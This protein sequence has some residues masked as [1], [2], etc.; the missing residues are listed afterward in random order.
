MNTIAII[1]SS[2]FFGKSLINHYQKTAKVKTK[3]YCISR[4]NFRIDKKNKNVLI[5]KKK[6][7]LEKVERLPKSDF[8]FYFIKHENTK[9]TK[10]YFNHFLNLLSKNNKNSKILFSSSGSVY[11]PVSKKKKF[12]ENVK[13]NQNNLRKYKNYKKKY[14]REKYYLEKKF[15]YLAKKGFKVSI[16]RC[17]SFYGENILR[18]N[19]V[20]SNILN[21]VRKKQNIVLNNKSN[22]LR[23]YMHEKDLARWLIKIC[24]NSNNKCPI[25]NVGSNQEVD[26]IKLSNKI[27]KK[28]NLR[29]IFKNKNYVSSDY[30]VPNTNKAKKVLN[31]SNRI[32]FNVNID[33]LIKKKSKF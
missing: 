30:Y 17:F 7:S 21:A 11:G 15:K 20:I 26:I 5:V 10:K 3:I 4:K 2:G 14:S 6:K 13:I 23:G 8:I 27:A 9:Q 28:Y 33:N 18:Y 22:L 29:V 19:Y 1:G 25:F 32:N 24:K 16:A 31:L 12:S